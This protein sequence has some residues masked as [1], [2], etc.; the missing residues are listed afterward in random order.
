MVPEDDARNTV[1]YED[2]Y[3]IDSRPAYAGGN[4]TPSRNGGKPCPTGFR[5][6]SDTNAHWLS[7]EELRELVEPHE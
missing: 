7:V 5:Y 2:C 6:S 3:V 4:G 1:E